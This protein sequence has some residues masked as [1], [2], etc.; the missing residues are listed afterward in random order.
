MK[1]LQVGGSKINE[2]E[3]DSEYELEYVDQLNFEDDELWQ[4]G[5]ILILCPLPEIVTELDL[6]ENL[7][8]QTKIMYASDQIDLKIFP[9][10]ERFEG[11][12]L[13]SFNSDELSHM[14][15]EIN[16]FFY[17]GQHGGGKQRITNV[18]FND[19]ENLTYNGNANVY[20]DLS[21][22]RNS[23]EIIGTW[24]Y[25]FPIQKAR[26]YSFW[27]EFKLFG[28][29]ELEYKFYVLYD[30]STDVKEVI[31]LNASDFN[32]PINFFDTNRSLTVHM[33]V[34][35]SGDGAVELGHMHYRRRRGKYG[36]FLPGDAR[37]VDNTTRQELFYYYSP[38]NLKPPLNVYFSGYQTAEG[39]E[40][41]YMMLKQGNPFILITDPR[42]D[43]GVFYRG[44][45]NLETQV[46]D[47]INGKLKDLQFK[48]SELTC[49]GI[50]M[51]SYAALYNAAHLSA[52]KVILGKPI[53]DLNVVIK[54]SKLVRP[55][56]FGIIMD[57]A[58]YLR[59]D[60]S[61]FAADLPNYI[62]NNIFEDM[63][64]RV[65]YMKNDDY[66]SN[67]E[68]FIDATKMKFKNIKKFG[69][70]GKHN[71]NSGPLFKRLEAS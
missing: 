27:P 4:Y 8:M 30:S 62:R 59:R 14:I 13:F 10:L 70:Q 47:I 66:D 28:N 20:I 58:T 5:L 12:T 34:K 65:A 40:G 29:A 54:N 33:T 31:T 49:I 9:E 7:L 55:D 53:I 37:L 41:Y 63:E 19:N 35:V 46:F 26:E 42:L 57:M 51:G 69:Y 23:K 52:G 2:D 44:T 39:F 71:D 68:K 17:G 50:S 25:G 32:E 24:K 21:D 16:S 67:F 56:D 61:D 43:G 18:I 45:E 22:N 3:L 15:S 36:T 1:I 60:F 6:F 48:K 64:F 38:G 11:T